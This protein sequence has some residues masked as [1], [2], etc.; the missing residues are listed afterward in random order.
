M[1]EQEVFP[2]RYV[3]RMR[4]KIS[5]YPIL[6][7]SWKIRNKVNVTERRRRRDRDIAKRKERTERTKSKRRNK[8]IDEP[9]SE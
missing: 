5:L 1:K 6:K 4:R 7:L 2:V 9:M 8:R 3:T